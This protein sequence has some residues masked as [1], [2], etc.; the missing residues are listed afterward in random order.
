MSTNAE[1]AKRYRRRKH[2]KKA[3]SIEQARITFP[4]TD[5]MKSKICDH[6]REIHQLHYDSFKDFYWG[7]YHGI[8][9]VCDHLNRVKCF[10]VVGDS[11]KYVEASDD[12]IFQALNY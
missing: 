5:D 6:L 10:C 8:K 2:Y 9:V 12:Q 3:Q 1:I 7:M 4:A 11:D